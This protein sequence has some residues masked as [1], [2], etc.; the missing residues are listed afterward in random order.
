MTVCGAP[1]A[2]SPSALSLLRHSW[3]Q[4]APLHDPGATRLQL[5]IVVLEPGV[6]LEAPPR[7]PAEGV[8][9]LGPDVRVDP[10]NVEPV[11]AGVGGD[12]AHGV[13]YALD[14]GCGKPQAAVGSEDAEALDVEDARVWGAHT[15]A[16][17]AGEVR[18]VGAAGRVE[19]AGFQAA[20]QA[21]Y[22]LGCGGGVAVAEEDGAAEE[23]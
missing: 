11:A 17:V 22:Y 13:E 7:V 21:A 9:V 10:A 2:H 1:A 16:G 5:E 20:H 12:R 14:C 19:R 8:V 15:L 4:H 3:R 23:A 6:S 18:R